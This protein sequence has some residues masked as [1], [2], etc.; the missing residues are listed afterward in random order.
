MYGAQEFLIAW[1]L[2]FGSIAEFF[3][4]LPPFSHPV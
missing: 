4:L 3:R 2:S 1:Q